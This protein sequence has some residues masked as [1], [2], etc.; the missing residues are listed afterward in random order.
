MRVGEID[1]MAIIN[2]DEKLLREAEPDG[3]IRL[4]DLAKDP[5]EKNDLAAEQP[6]KVKAL[7]RRM[8][9]I[10]ASC[11]RSRDGADYRY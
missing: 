7:M 3:R 2:G 4:Y 6:E 5:L 11:Q 1:G 8:L 9:E 10:D